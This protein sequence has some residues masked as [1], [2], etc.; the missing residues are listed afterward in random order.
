[1]VDLRGR[2]FFAVAQG[3]VG[4]LYPD[5]EIFTVA[6]WVTG[7]ASASPSLPHCL[8]DPNVDPVWYQKPL[9]TVR[10]NQVLRG[11]WLNGIWPGE[12]GGFHTPLD[13]AVDAQNPNVIY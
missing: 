10:L 6:G 2:F 5:G 13:V 7:R 1:M 12:T 3:R 9:G 11:T 4:I 8:A